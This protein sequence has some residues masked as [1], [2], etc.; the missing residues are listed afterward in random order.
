MDYHPLLSWL[1]R[2][3]KDGKVWWTLWNDEGKVW[4][5]TSV[6]KHMVPGKLQLDIDLHMRLCHRKKGHYKLCFTFKVH[7]IH[8]KWEHASHLSAS[9]FFAMWICIFSNREIEFISGP[10][11]S[12]MNLSFWEQHHRNTSMSVLTCL[13]ILNWLTRL[14][15]CQAYLLRGDSRLRPH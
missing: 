11:G 4:E 10:L 7:C 3:T 5:N 6:M 14:C 2:K 15:F 8:A 1:A 12:G 9:G 13:K